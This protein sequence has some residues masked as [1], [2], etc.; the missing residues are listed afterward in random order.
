M[1]YKKAISVASMFVLSV[2]VFSF[3]SL[4][5]V[6]AQTANER[7]GEAQ[8]QVQERKDKYIENRCERVTF[9]IDNRIERYNSNWQRHTERYL[10]IK[11]NV[12]NFINKVEGKGYDV[13]D[14]RSVLKNLGSQI[15]SAANTYS[16]VIEQLNEAKTFA[17]GNSEGQFRSAV[18]TANDY[19]Q[20]F[21]VQVRDIGDFVREE[22]R[23]AIQ[24]VRDQK[25][26]N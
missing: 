5:P 18:E 8:K 14:L 1:N 11:N 15:Q 2:S 9:N 16:T 22:L 24:A 7:L 26:R 20:D 10:K 12:I 23:P 3:F 6:A 19:L 21:R 25:V 13:A 4:M 17:C